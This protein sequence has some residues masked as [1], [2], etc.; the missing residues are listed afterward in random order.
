MRAIRD[1][2]TCSTRG[3]VMPAI[4]DLLTFLRLVAA[5]DRVVRH[6]PVPVEMRRPLTPYVDGRP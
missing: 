1:R 3:H 5:T 2:L 4:R 6:Q